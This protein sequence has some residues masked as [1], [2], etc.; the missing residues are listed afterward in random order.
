MP[1]E[2][3]EKWDVAV[4]GNQLRYAGSSRNPSFARTPGRPSPRERGPIIN[5]TERYGKPFKCLLRVA[6]ASRCQRSL[7][8]RE[9]VVEPPWVPG[10]GGRRADHVSPQIGPRGR[11]SQRRRCGGQI[12]CN[13]E[14]NGRKVSTE[15]MKPDVMQRTLLQTQLLHCY[16]YVFDNI[17]L[18][19]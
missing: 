4:W 13:V 14:V 6:A 15:R 16:K 5:G 8:H 11:F 7:Q 18:L 10:Q 3:S 2:V 19:S 12:T 17:T 1:G 9:S